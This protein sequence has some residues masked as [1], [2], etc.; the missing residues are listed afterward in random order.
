MDASLIGFRPYYRNRVLDLLWS[1]WTAAGV[2]GHGKEWRGVP[3]DPE[4]LLL[5]SCTIARHDARLFDG[6]LEWIDLNG[7]YV[8][9]QRL[10]KIVASEEFSGEDVLRAVASLAKDPA[11]AAKWSGTV[12]AGGRPAAQAPLFYLKDGHPMPSVKDRDPVFAEHGLLRD[13]FEPRGVAA[14]FRPDLAANLILRLRALVGVNARCEI[15][16]Y[17]V[18]NRG[19]SPRSLAREAYYFPATVSKAM[20][21]MRDSGYVISH[22]EGRRRYHRLVPDSWRELLRGDAAPGWIIWPRLYSGL[23]L[24][25]NFL[26]HE[27]RHDDSPLAQASSLRRLLLKSVVDRFDSSGL[28]FTFGDLSAYPGERLLSFFVK[29]MSALLDLLARMGRM[30]A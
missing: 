16:A 7:R 2:S 17:L 26:W 8:S 29:R 12:D 5:V 24:V 22:M 9:I 10:K 20:K 6:M 19:G 1:Q 18:L 14:T 21:D 4:A 28:D 15:L 23:E 30:S 25:W 3:L 11:S 13:R 27:R